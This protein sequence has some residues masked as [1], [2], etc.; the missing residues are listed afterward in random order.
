MGG[1]IVDLLLFLIILLVLLVL[2][3]LLILLVFKILILPMAVCVKKK[4]DQIFL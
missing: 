4:E 2:L 1:Q 3:V